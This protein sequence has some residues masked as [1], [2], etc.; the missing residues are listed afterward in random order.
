[1]LSYTF[2]SANFSRPKP[3]KNTSCHPTALW[4]HK[5]DWLVFVAAKTSPLAMPMYALSGS[6]CQESCQRSG[7]AS[8]VNV[9]LQMQEPF[10]H[11]Y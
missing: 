4:G 5:K 7:Q 10:P 8:P 11:A 6:I 9:N 1:M 3:Q 2:I